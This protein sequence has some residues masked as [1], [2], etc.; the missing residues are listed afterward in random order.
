MNRRTRQAAHNSC[1]QTGMLERQTKLL[2]VALITSLLLPGCSHMTKSG[3]QQAAY[4]RYINRSMS[5]RDKQ[6]LKLARKYKK[7]KIP[8]SAPLT[9][10][11][12]TTTAAANEPR[13]ISAGGP[14]GGQ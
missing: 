13:S 12:M 2:A 4:Q 3:R 8:K 10:Q 7:T 6:R 9:D 11:K 1:F 14:P 5:M